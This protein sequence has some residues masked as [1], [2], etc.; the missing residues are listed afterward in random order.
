MKGM[1]KIK[2]GNS[3]RGVLDYAFENDR[4]QIIGGNMVGIHPRELAK[5]FGQSRAL[6]EEV[7]KPVWH[8]SLRLPKGERIE[9]KKL[10]EIGDEYMRRIGFTDMHQRAYVLHD[11]P[12]GQHIHI[13]ASRV[14]VLPGAGLYLGKNENLLSTR[15]ISEL[16]REFNLTITRGLDYVFNEKGEYQIDSTSMP[17]VSRRAPTHGEIGLAERT[18]DVPIRM[19]L[20]ALIDAATIDKPG[21]A[22]FID[23]M[24]CAGVSIMPSGKTGAAQ[25]I[26]FAFGGQPFKG[27]DLGK[28]Y[29]WKGLQARIDYSLERDQKIINDLRLKVAYL[30]DQKKNEILPSLNSIP[31][32]GKKYRNTLDLAFDRQGNTYLWK[33]SATPAFVDHGDKISIKSNSDTG[34][35]AALQLSCDKWGGNIEVSGSE[36]YRRKAWLIGSQIGLNIIGYRPNKTDIDEFNRLKANREDTNNERRKQRENSKD[37][38]GGKDASR[39]SDQDTSRTINIDRANG[40]QHGGSDRRGAISIEQQSGSDTY[41]N[42]LD[43][44][45]ADSSRYLDGLEATTA[46]ASETTIMASDNHANINRSGLESVRVVADRVSDIASFFR[47]RSKSISDSEKP[48]DDIPSN[49]G[50]ESIPS[51]KE[52]KIAIWRRQHAA[53]GAPLYRITFIDR[54][55]GRVTLNSG[56]THSVLD[57]NKNKIDGDRYDL[58]TAKEIEDAMGV[59][60]GRNKK[61]YDIYVTPADPD[62]YYILVDD[63]HEHKYGF[64][65]RYSAFLQSGFTPILIQETSADNKQ[66]IIKVHRQSTEHQV[67]IKFFK[68]MDVM[69]GEKNC[70]GGP[71]HA[72][73]MAGFSNKKPSRNNEF[74]KIVETN[75]GVICEKAKFVIAE[76]IRAGAV[77]KEK[78][79]N[80]KI[81]T[82][83]IAAIKNHVIDPLGRHDDAIVNACKSEF[84]RVIGLV[85]KGHIKG[86]LDMSTVDFRVAKALLIAGYPAD[87]IARTIVDVSPDICVR[88]RGREI[89]YA[90]LTVLNAA[91]HKDVV[92]ARPAKT[93]LGNND[94]NLR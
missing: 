81:K 35:K 19:Q 42:P 39:N 21:F 7:G 76:M 2:R 52:V 33:N 22:D 91:S 23:R 4:G 6:R 26:S 10:A 90:E 84:G 5:E 32:T 66:A 67:A 34:I 30:A 56:R 24:T 40:H 14:S 48:T 72:F 63:I 71:D 93:R 59:L 77:E 17:D 49:K 80:E 47:N 1:Q 12:D 87:K 55:V 50:S 25:G 16:E 51:G 92:N 57:K 54:D 78:T 64:E 68:D 53:M 29:A 8:N 45:P 13:I 58:K 20:Q 36:D 82:M 11:E 28:S 9:P 15:I 83:R 46:E 41:G 79:R 74:T 62:F 60:M 44:V 37:A 3:F 94:L 89:E 70:Q 38:R 27:S 65:G 18:G 85:E 61:G 73:R 75:P 88:K 69:Y 43:R 31:H 86:D